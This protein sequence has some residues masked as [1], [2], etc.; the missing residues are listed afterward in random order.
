MYFSVVAWRFNESFH[1]LYVLSFQAASV[2][3]MHE[4]FTIPLHLPFGDKSS[5]IPMALGDSY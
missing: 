5:I 1:Y 2:S 4:D 3:A